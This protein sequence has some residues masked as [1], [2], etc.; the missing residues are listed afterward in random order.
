M[1]VILV[2]FDSL[3]K[4][5][6]PIY[7]KNIKIKT[8]NFLRL[9]E[10]SVTFDN[11]YVGSMPCMPARREIHTGRR[12]FLHREWGPLEPYDNSMPEILKN[13]G[14]Y[15]HLIS[16]HIHYWEEGGA[17]YHTKYS[18]WEIVRGQEGDHWKGSVKDPDYPE[19]V[20]VTSNQSNTGVSSMWRS[21]WVN[22]EYIKNE[23]DQPM[24]KVFELGEEFISKNYKSDK[25][26]LQIETFDPH[27]PFY[28][29][30]HF[31]NLYEKNYRGKHYDW[32]RGKVEETQEEINHIIN[33]Y[34]ALVTMCDK[35]LGKII[36]L[37]DL[38]DL[39]EDTMLIVGTD[40][41]FMLGEHG[42]WGKNQVPYFNEV[43]NIPLF[44]Y[45]PRLKLKKER[46]NS[47]VQLIDW[48][49]TILNFFG[50]DIPSE[51]EGKD[52]TKTIENDEP[53]RED[54]MFGV[55]SGHVNIT[56]GKN[57]YMRAASKNKENLI[58]NYTLI[59]NMMHKPFSIDSLSKAEFV[60]GF[61]FTKGLK[62]LKIP[63]KDKYGVNRFGTMLFDLEKD[64]NQNKPIKDNEL[65]NKMI[66][67]LIRN[68]KENDSP[69]EQ[70]IRLGLNDKNF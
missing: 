29:M 34:K 19:V 10:K 66:K 36:E 37:M 35:N 9:A 68:M 48:A 64:P 18:S 3:N 7:N 58:Y 51:M 20:K 21:D 30:D 1:K 59:P 52:L 41:G 12:N 23:K 5:Y 55:F 43:A 47:L 62:L 16:D 54:A 67:K 6:L 32:P 13:N 39:W 40:H 8:P 33:K 22:R 15:S 4:R 65:E 25:W 46:R 56:D 11:C 42:Y 53:V 44:I 26:F 24:T 63:A 61:D 27:E 31:T 2:L 17:N 14:I 60:E 70:Y 69:K 38:Y 50:L 45:D 28:V 49:P 57:V